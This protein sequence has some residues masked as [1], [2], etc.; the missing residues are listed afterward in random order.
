MAFI[1]KLVLTSLAALGLGQVLPGVHFPGF[2]T[3]L[4]FVLILGVMNAIVKPVLKLISLPIT[5]LTLGLFTLVIN[6]VVIQL[7]DLLIPGDLV[8]GFITSL[9]FGFLLSLVT[10]LIDALFSGK[11]KD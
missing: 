4:I 9:L 8:H 6:V 10:S 5:L 11:S 2:G 7:A 3:A 1:L